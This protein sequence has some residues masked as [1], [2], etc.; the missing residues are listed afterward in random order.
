MLGR[1]W[2]T[3]DPDPCSVQMLHLLETKEGEGAILSLCSAKGPLGERVGG[4]LTH[5]SFE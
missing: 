3:S 1:M 4:P 2:A 5:T